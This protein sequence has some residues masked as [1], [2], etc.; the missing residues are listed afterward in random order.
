MINGWRHLTKL[1]VELK[2]PF[3]PEPAQLG[4]VYR[5]KQQR[6]GRRE[7]MR[8][9]AIMAVVSIFIYAVGMALTN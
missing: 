1:R 8:L 6:Q 3:R 9:L 4:D 7:L 5:R 2:K